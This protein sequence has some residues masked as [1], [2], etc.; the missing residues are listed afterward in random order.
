MKDKDK[1]TDFWDKWFIP[2][3]VV[4]VVFVFIWLSNYFPF[5]E[6]LKSPRLF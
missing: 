4:L 6:Q 3:L 1:C 5:P 2:I